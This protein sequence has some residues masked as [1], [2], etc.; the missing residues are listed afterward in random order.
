MSQKKISVSISEELYDCIEVLSEDLEISK[1]QLLHQALISFLYPQP[2]KIPA[3]SPA[4]RTVDPI[5]MDEIKGTIKKLKE[6]IE[7]L[8][9]DNKFLKSRAKV[10]YM[11]RGELTRIQQPD[12]ELDK[13]PF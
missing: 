12:E 4:T 3:R 6:A 10:V 13:F 7:Q 1:S 2:A 5:E 9:E 8:Q 11:K